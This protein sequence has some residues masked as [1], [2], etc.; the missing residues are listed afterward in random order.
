MVLL[1]FVVLMLIQILVLLLTKPIMIRMLVISCLISI[2]HTRLAFTSGNDFFVITLQRLLFF[3]LFFT[4]DIINTICTHTNSYATDHMFQGIHQSYASAD[5]SW[6]DVTPDEIKRLIGLLNY[7]GLVKVVGSVEK[8]WSKKR[9]YHG[10]WARA[11]FKAIITLLH[12]VDSA[13]EVPADKL[14]KVEYFKTRC[15]ALYQ[16]R[17]NVA[18][19][20]Q[21]VKS[22]HRSGIR[23]YIKY[24][25]SLN[26]FNSHTFVNHILLP[27]FYCFY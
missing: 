11:R 20:E 6:Q 24:I 14:R 15:R 21:M 3:F 8:Y 12:V 27:L 18:T 9:L 5:G 17:Q 10:L 2:L 23:Q 19:D 13:T 7:F 1:L 4:V 22:R 16:P 25:Y 26:L